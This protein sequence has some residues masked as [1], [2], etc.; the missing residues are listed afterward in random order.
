MTYGEG[1]VRALGDTPH[2][3]MLMYDNN[4][5]ARNMTGSVAP[6]VSKCCTITLQ[7]SAAITLAAVAEIACQR[8]SSMGR[9]V[10]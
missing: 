5:V 8:L 1:L 3:H 7:Y 2:Q 10:F 9:H 6:S 4:E